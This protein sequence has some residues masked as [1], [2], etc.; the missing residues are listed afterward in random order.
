M[1]VHVHR[2]DQCLVHRFDQCLVHASCSVDC[3]THR[4]AYICSGLVV[5][6]FLSVSSVFLCLCLSLMHL[7]FS[8]S[9]YVSMSVSVSI[10]LL[11]GG[12]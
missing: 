9:L 11:P 4:N 12:S 2:F 3:T 1:I 5:L 6:P 8:V 10:V 7:S